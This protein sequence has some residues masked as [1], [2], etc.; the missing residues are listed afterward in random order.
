MA[1]T[2]VESGPAGGQH[3]GTRT[4]SLPQN[5]QAAVHELQQQVSACAQQVRSLKEGQGRGNRDPEVQALVAQLNKLK[6]GQGDASLRMDC[7]C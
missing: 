6:V 4:G 1:D 3:P 5:A 2:L 7:I